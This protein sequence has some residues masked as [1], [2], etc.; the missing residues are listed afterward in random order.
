MSKTTHDTS[1]I[2]F[3]KVRLLLSDV[4]RPIPPRVLKGLFNPSLEYKNTYARNQWEDAQYDLWEPVVIEDTDAY[5][6]QFI[7]KKKALAFK[8]GWEFVGKNPDTIEYIKD[9]ISWLEIAQGKSFRVL[10]KEAS[11]EILSKGTSVWFKHRDTKSSNGKPRKLNGR[12]TKPVAGYFIAPIETVQLK[13]DNNGRIL[14]A[15]QVMPDGRKT[16]EFA[17]EDVAIFTIDKKVGQPIGTPIVEPVKDDI[18]AL[19]RI[20]ENLDLLVYQ[21]LFPI[22]QYIVGTKEKPASVYSNG[23]DE[24]EEVENKVAFLPPEGVIVTPERHEIKMIGVEGKALK[25]EGIVKHFKERVQAGL[26]MSGVD[27]GEG[28]SATRSTANTMSGNTIDDVKDIQDDI[29]AQFDWQILNEL[30]LEGDFSFNPL[31]RDNTVN[32]QFKEI[33]VE[34]KIKHENHVAQMFEQNLFNEDDSRREIGYEVVPENDKEWRKKTYWKQYKEPETLMLSGDEAYLM[35]TADNP[36]TSLE[37]GNIKEGQ[38]M[39]KDLEKAAAKAKAAAKPAAPTRG[40]RAAQGTNRPSNQHGTRTGPKLSKDSFVLLDHIVDESFADIINDIQV[41]LQNDDDH[42]WIKNIISIW[43]DRLT[44]QFTTHTVN[45]FNNGAVKFG[46]T[47]YSTYDG[48]SRSNEIREH[49]KY[50]IHK[51]ANDLSNRIGRLDGTEDANTAMSLVEIHRGRL[52]AIYKSELVKA[53]NYGLVYGMLMDGYIEAKIIGTDAEICESCKHYIGQV[54]KLRDATLKSIPS[55]HPN[56]DC[57]LEPV[58]ASRVKFSTQDIFTDSSNNNTNNIYI[59]TFEDSAH[60]RMYKKHLSVAGPQKAV[61]Y[62]EWIPPKRNAL[63]VGLDGFLESSEYTVTDTQAF[64]SWSGRK[65]ALQYIDTEVSPGVSEEKIFNAHYF[66]KDQDNNQLILQTRFGGYWPEIILHV[67]DSDRKIAKKLI[68]SFDSYIRKNNFLKGHTVD[69]N[70]KFV[71]TDNTSMEDVIYADD[72]KDQLDRNVVGFLDKIQIYAKNK[73]PTKRGILLE[74]PPGTGKSI[75]FKALSNTLKD[76]VSCIWATS[77]DMD[78]SQQSGSRLIKWLYEMARDLSPTIIFLEDIDTFG[79]SRDTGK[80]DPITGELLNQLDGLKS[81]DG[82]VTMA[83]TNF[84][85]QL[86]KALSDRPG[87]FDVKIHLGP[88]ALPEAKKMLQRFLSEVKVD[89]ELID[90]LAENV[91]GLT[92]AY[93]REVAMQAVSFAIDDESLDKED[94][95]IIKEEYLSKAIKQVKANRKQYAVEDCCS[96]VV[97]ETPEDASKLEA[98][99]KTELTNLRARYP[100]AEDGSLIPRARAICES[101]VKEN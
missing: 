25:A 39:K 67:K 54:I 57:S 18:R 81:N 64:D 29:E 42:K 84:V 98:C 97:M 76:G 85:G 3:A 52:D 28:G 16:K 94:I 15:R 1:N 49:T 95:A 89:S 91:V 74:G 21:H 7:R 22:F 75:M 19:R 37:R 53:H 12:M 88:P 24:V 100:K 26:G 69:I 72:I 27:F 6:R 31:H 45:E 20:E 70:G 77:G 36:N 65:I 83:S 51:L 93:I 80:T 99:I 9:R 82:V 78:D 4:A 60:T 44:K 96:S 13:R 32:L 61:V 50:Y 48:I 73:Q 66:L 23:T 2:R 79:Q 71:K 35:A 59:E 46:A 8:S 87:R 92:G 30:L 56:C 43:E 33:D 86:D 17:G 62:H 5:F 68:D 38:E 63:V 34:A 47:S 58:E 10:L 11:H 90:K 101:K 40:S 41:Y 14:K 55:F